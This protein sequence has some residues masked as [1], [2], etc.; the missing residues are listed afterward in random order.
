MAPSVLFTIWATPAL[1]S[2]AW[3]SAAHCT[4]ESVPSVQ[5]APLSLPTDFSRNLVKLPVVP[6][7]SL[8]CTTV[9]AVSGR[10]T[11]EFSAAMAASFHLVI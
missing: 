7:E 10:V 3:V 9:I 2:P 4:V 11:P 8:R 1:P 6:L 5:M